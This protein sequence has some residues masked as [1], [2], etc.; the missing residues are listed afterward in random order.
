MFAGLF[1]VLFGFA[2]FMIL[3]NYISEFLGIT[4]S[5][6]DREF[7]RR[8]YMSLQEQWQREEAFNELRRMRQNMEGG[9]NYCDIDHRPY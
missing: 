5:M 1:T 8:H 6:M 7:Q 3:L 4:M 2:G 9:R